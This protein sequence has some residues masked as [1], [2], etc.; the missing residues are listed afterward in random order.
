[1]VLMVCAQEVAGGGGAP[2]SQGGW[3]EWGEW[4]EWG[5]DEPGR[6]GRCGR[7]AGAPVSQGSAHRRARAV[8]LGKAGVAERTSRSGVP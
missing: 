2:V 5:A 7:G 8:A 4:G 1:M 6:V 3:G